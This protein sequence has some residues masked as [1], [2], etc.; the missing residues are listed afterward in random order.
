M[1]LATISALTSL[2]QFNLYGNH[3]EYIEPELRKDTRGCVCC[4]L[5]ASTSLPTVVTAL[6][7]PPYPLTHRNA[8]DVIAEAWPNLHFSIGPDPH[9]SNSF[10]T[11]PPGA[12]EELKVC[13]RRRYMLETGCL[14]PPYLLLNRCWEAWR[15]EE[16]ELFILPLL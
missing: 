3:F 1:P 13:R 15:S 9:W 16:R 5:S 10:Y 14:L 12:W 7:T 2:S 4:C 8:V 6:F 11:A